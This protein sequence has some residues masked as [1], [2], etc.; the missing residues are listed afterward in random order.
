[1]K[2]IYNKVKH[3]AACVFLVAAV[4]SCDN[5]IEDIGGAQQNY[6]TVYGMLHANTNLTVFAKAIKLTGLE[7]TL[8]T[9]DD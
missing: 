3:I 4:S 1:M 7:S 5:E 2:N 8:D 9:P 6:N